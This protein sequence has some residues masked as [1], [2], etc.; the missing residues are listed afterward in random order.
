MKGNRVDSEQKIPGCGFHQ[1]QPFTYRSIPGN[2]RESFC[3]PTSFLKLFLLTEE[4]LWGDRVQ[5]WARCS[6]YK[7]KDLPDQTSIKRQASKTKKKEN[8]RQ[9]DAAP[10]KGTRRKHQPL[11]GSGE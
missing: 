11:E 2:C 9:L 4:L 8:K 6:F 5:L 10:Q 7:F 1:N 3:L